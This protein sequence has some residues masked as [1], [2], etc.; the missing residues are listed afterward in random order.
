MVKTSNVHLSRQSIAPVN[1]I[2]APPPPHT[3]G[4]LGCCLFLGGVYVVVHLLFSVL[5][6]VCGGSV[7]VFVLVCITLRPFQFINH[8]EEE[9]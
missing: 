8:L 9:G 6:I 1:C 4:S 2:K 5:P 3:H 7:F